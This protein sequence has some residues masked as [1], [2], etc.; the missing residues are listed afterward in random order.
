MVRL[1]KGPSQLSL[2]PQKIYVWKKLDILFHLYSSAGR[3]YV[4]RK[5]GPS[6]LRLRAPK[7]YD[8]EGKKKTRYSFFIYLRQLAVCMSKETRALTAKA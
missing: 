7:N 6:Q 1:H 4:K 2:R 3:L 5:K 8:S